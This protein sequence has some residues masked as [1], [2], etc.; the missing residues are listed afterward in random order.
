MLIPSVSL[1]IMKPQKGKPVSKLMSYILAGVQKLTIRMLTMGK[2]E[3]SGTVSS[4]V[5]E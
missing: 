3:R 4:C 2:V 1:S 5:L